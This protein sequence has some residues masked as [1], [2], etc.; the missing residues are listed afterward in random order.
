M[1]EIADLECGTQGFRENHVLPPKEQ[2]GT[3][4]YSMV[5]Q[6]KILDMSQLVRLKG[7]LFPFN[8]IY[9]PIQLV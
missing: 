9:K 6:D 3:N 2:T 7:R 8:P 5:Y 4:I 1:G